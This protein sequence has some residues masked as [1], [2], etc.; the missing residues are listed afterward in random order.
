MFEEVHDGDTVGK[1]V[2]VGSAGPLAP[3]VV[4]RRYGRT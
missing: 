1:I 4:S 2:I 3:S